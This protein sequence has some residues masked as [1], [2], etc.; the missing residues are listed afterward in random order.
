MLY[1]DLYETTIEP[2]NKLEENLYSCDASPDACVTALVSKMFAVPTEELPE[3]K[4]KPATAEELRA[5]A[6]AARE[7]R[8]AAEN[9]TPA[10][11]EVESTPLEDALEKMRV[12]ESKKEE[13]VEGGETL[14]GFARIYSGTISKGTSIACILPKYHNHL[15]PKH[16]KNEKHIVVTEVEAL[17]VM[18]GRELVSV[19]RVRAGNVFAIK[20]LEGKV[21]RNAT[22][23]APGEKGV[24]EGA[25]L[26]ALK[27][28]IVNLGGVARMVRGIRSQILKSIMFTILWYRLLPSCG[29]HWSQSHP[30]TCLS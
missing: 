10:P 5:K 15:D 30:R 21:W 9:G 8:K 16:A 4:K 23:C 26:S 24:Q 29:L 28:C 12:E 2:K 14:L 13:K 11:S 3:N 7:A 17:Y 1:P 27:D 18:M 22:L 25:D 20:G 19:D 6:I